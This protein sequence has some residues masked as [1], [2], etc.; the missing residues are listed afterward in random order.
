MKNRWLTQINQNRERYRQ[1]CAKEPSMCIF[2]KDY[3]QDAV[4]QNDQWS[5][6]LYEKGGNI[7]G[8][9]VFCY[10]VRSRGISISQPIQTQTNGVWIK[11]FTGKNEYKR[12]EYEKEVFT[13]LITELEK[14]PLIHY[15]QTF[16]VEITN[17]LPFYWKGFRQSTRYTYRIPDI[18]DPEAAIAGFSSGKRGNLNHALRSGL[19]VKYDL[20]AEE[21]YANHEMTLKKQGKTISY[22]YET[23]KKIVNTVYAHDCGRTIYAVDA[24]N[25]IHA[26][27][28][29]IW[30]ANCGFYLIN[31]VDP[32]FRDS[33]AAALLVAQTLRFLA[34]KGVRQF[35][36]E[37]S[38]IEGVEKSYRQFG[39]KQMPYFAISKEYYGS[40]L[41]WVYEKAESLLRKCV[42]RG[43]RAFGK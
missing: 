13:G 9:L 12:L 16:T 7:M 24:Q 4:C 35:D 39:T 8:S 5:A 23:L 17:W 34:D 27:L 30:D 3:W 26:A 10:Q 21:F 1:L 2:L 33:G 20:P 32:D 18:S 22:P 29:I 28:L 6:V 38:M 41:I 43:R 15:S 40:P 11:P 31:T 25:Q 19:T 42:Q 37:G 14:L 36:F